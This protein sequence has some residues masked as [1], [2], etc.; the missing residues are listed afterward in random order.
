LSDA[1][2]FIESGQRVALV[3]ESGKGKSSLFN[4]L[5]RYYE[6]QQGAI[7]IDGQDIASVGLSHLRH[8]ISIVEQSPMMSGRTLR[9]NIAGTRNQDHDEKIMLAAEKSGLI[10]FI[11]SFQDGLDT[12]TGEC[13]G[14]LS[15]GEKQKSR[16]LARHVK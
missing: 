3:R 16:F 10:A 6:P 14:L 11:N 15:G 8:K 5:F 1:S 7:Y 13:G 4:L 12:K 9:E 2:F